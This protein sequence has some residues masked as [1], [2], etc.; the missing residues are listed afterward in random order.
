MDRQAL[1][2]CWTLFR[3]DYTV[4]IDRLVCSPEL[5]STFISQVRLVCNCDDEEAILWELSICLICN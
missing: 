2:D 5:R 4:S 3:R 1:L